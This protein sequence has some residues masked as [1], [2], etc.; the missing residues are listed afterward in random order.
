MNSSFPRRWFTTKQEPSCS[1]LKSP[2][3][4]GFYPPF[5]AGWDAEQS[6]L[7]LGARNVTNHRDAGALGSLS[8]DRFSAP[9]SSSSLCPASSSQTHRVSPDP[10]EPCCWMP[11]R[12]RAPSPTQLLPCQD[13]FLLTKP[14][15]AALFLSRCFLASLARPDVAGSGISGPGLRFLVMVFVPRPQLTSWDHKGPPVR[16]QRELPGKPRGCSRLSIPAYARSPEEV[17]CGFYL[18]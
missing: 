11:S 7:L 2:V 6:R 13:S 5:S 3:C 1:L 8:G 9:R 17:K 16:A 18:S 4:S 14:I 12:S 15:S 10:P